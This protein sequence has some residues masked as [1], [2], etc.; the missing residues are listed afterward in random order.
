MTYRNL[1]KLIWHYKVR[2]ES[3]LRTLKERLVEVP[4]SVKGFNVDWQDYELDFTELE[5]MAQLIH[6]E[7]RIDLLDDCLS[8][9]ESDEIHMRIKLP[10]AKVWLSG[11]GAQE[12]FSKEHNLDEIISAQKNSRVLKA[13]H[14][15]TVGIVYEKDDKLRYIEVTL[16]DKYLL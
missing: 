11:E 8:E 3:E 1:N 5:S 9:E 2:N 10:Y 6:P 16:T 13:P 7:M 14:Y 4:V 15:N 12:D